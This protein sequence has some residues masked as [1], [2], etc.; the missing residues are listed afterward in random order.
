RSTNRGGSYS[1]SRSGSG[2]S[3]TRT[4]TGTTRS[5][6][7]YSGTRNVTRDGD[8]VTVNRNASTSGGA[9]RS[10]QKTYEMD[11]GRVQSVE[12]DTNVT[13]RGGQSANWEGKAER[14]GAGW[15]F[16]GEGH[17]R[18]GQKVE[19]EGYGA[20]G[21][22]GSGVVAD[23]EGGRYGDRTVAAGR[24]YGGPVYARNLP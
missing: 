7:S 2:N 11:D 13:G 1:T 10:T 14:S 4:T 22:Y 24:G 21:R 3:T 16:E 20:R 8:E 9:S 5:G 12:R 6:E 23:V 18:Y 15:E 19:A 17:N